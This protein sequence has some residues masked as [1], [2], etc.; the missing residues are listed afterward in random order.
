MEISTH[1]SIHAFIRHSRESALSLSQMN[2][3]FRLY[4]HGAGS[5]N[6]LADHLGISM[7]GVSQ[8]LDQLI[9]AGYLARTTD[10]SD[11]RV[12]LISLTEKGTQAVEQ[13]MRARHSWIKDL[14]ESLT[15]AE[16]AQLLPGLILLRDRVHRL[17][18]KADQNCKCNQRKASPPD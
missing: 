7:A 8:L 1:R 18:K 17:M 9:E 12:K 4:H 3:L 16:K 11:R 10:P 2:S 15:P 13:S 5:V 6:E 14:A